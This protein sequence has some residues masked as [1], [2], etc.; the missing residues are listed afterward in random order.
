MDGASHQH[1]RPSVTE[2]E[3]MQRAEEIA[4]ILSDNTYWHSHGRNIDINRL[5]AL[6]L[7]IEDYSENQDLKSA[8]RGYNDPLTAY[9][10]RMGMPLIMHHHSQSL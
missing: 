4:S 8:I 3:K 6:K 7:E 10:D 1:P 5:S 9:A 2:K